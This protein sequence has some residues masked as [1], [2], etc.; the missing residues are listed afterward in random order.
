MVSREEIF[1]A[2]RFILGRDPEGETAYQAHQSHSDWAAM[3][4]V[5]MDSTEAR[6][7]VARIICRPPEPFDYFRPLLVFLHVEK[8]GGTSLLDALTRGQ[9]MRVAPHGLSHLPSLTL[10]FLNQYDCIGGHFTY[11]EAA[12]LPRHPKKIVTILR[13]PAERLISF[14]RFHRAHGEDGGANPVVDLARRLPAADFFRHPDIAGSHRVFNAY[15]HSFAGLPAHPRD[16]TADAMHDAT[17]RSLEIIGS[18]T[19]AGIT[20]R[21]E[22]S[23]RLFRHVDLSLPVPDALNRTDGLDEKKGFRSVERVDHNDDLTEAI[24]PLIACD[25]I[26]YDFANDLLSSRLRSTAQKTDAPP[27]D[28]KAEAPLSRMKFSK[29]RVMR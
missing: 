26:I 6:M 5:M 2:Y 4:Q 3:R 21:M 8:T 28:P 22:D 14:Y 20:E 11:Q 29:F 16:C 12:A 15:V 24:A 17:E 19:A 10:G 9:D 18:L 1:W 25:T 13:D 27:V 7:N 23:I